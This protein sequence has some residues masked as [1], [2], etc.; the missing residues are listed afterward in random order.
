[1]ACR[2]DPTGR[3][4]GGGDLLEHH[5]RTQ[6]V[7]HGIGVGMGTVKRPGGGITAPIGPLSDTLMV[8]GVPYLL[9]RGI[10]VVFMPWAAAQA[11]VRAATHH[12][13][14]FICILYQPL[15][16]P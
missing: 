12:P 2:I 14:P 11:N 9:F 15:G 3:G 5:S 16:H 8:I 13:P 7:G 6:D 1:M 4:L 10:G